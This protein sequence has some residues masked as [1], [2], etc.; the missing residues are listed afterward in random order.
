M[1]VR[2]DFQR[3]IRTCSQLDFGHSLPISFISVIGVFAPVLSRPVWQHVKVLLTGAIL[4]PGKRTVTA[5]LQSMGRRTASDFQTYHRV[6]SRAVWSPLQASRLL[7]R[8][9][10]MVC[11]PQGGGGVGLDDTSERRRGAPITAQGISRDPVRSAHAP[12]GKASGLR[13]LG[14]L[15]RTPPSWA[16]RVW[17]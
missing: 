6:L 17:A 5:M 15:L 12:M 8:L 3:S 4:A 7:L 16:K 14:C 13:W 1:I 11:I 10:V 2:G 9:L